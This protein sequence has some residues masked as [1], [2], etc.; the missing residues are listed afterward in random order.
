MA[1]CGALS[2]RQDGGSRRR[3]HDGAADEPS[4][5]RGGR[6]WAWAWNA[7]KKLARA[8]A[9]VWPCWPSW[10]SPGRASAR[11][12]VSAWGQTPPRWRLA[13]RD[14]ACSQQ[15]PSPMSERPQARGASAR[16]RGAV[17]RYQREAILERPQRAAQGPAKN[18]PALT[19][20]GPRL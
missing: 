13:R 5:P 3:G 12:T 19:A 15:T 9:P 16:G 1:V 10:P 2:G 8:V 20:C 11:L 6:V 18:R 17:A 7:S 4:E 14:A